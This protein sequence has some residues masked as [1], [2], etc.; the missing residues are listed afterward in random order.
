MDFPRFVFTSPGPDKCNGG[1]YGTELVEDK[2]EYDVALKAGFYST[3]PEALEAVG[4]EV[5]AKKPRMKQE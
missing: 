1:T 3:L 4:K 2:A 5:Q